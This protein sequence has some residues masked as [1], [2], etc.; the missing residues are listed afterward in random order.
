MFTTLLLVVALG[1]GGQ[2]QSTQAQSSQQLTT[3]VERVVRLADL[4][5]QKLELDQ[6][7][8]TERLRAG[9]NH[10]AVQAL[11]VQLAEVESAIRRENLES[12][13]SDAKRLSE[14][15]AALELRIATD[16][17]SLGE[18]HPTIRATET[19]LAAVKEQQCVAAVSALA[20]GGEAELRAAITRQPATLAPYLELAGLY[21][22]AD[23]SADAAQLLTDV[24]AILKRAGGR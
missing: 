7:L 19:Q 12:Y 21:V 9:E 16:R 4:Q 24:L 15:R 11:L 6:Q 8:A 3:L 23:R 10:P 2:A 22:L 20:D 18:S 13:Q 1:S 5:R 17:K 14:G